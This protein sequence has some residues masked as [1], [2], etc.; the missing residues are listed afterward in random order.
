MS[1]VREQAKAARQ[2]GHSSRDQHQDREIEG[3][4]D[5]LDELAELDRTPDTEQPERR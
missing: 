5:L 3:Q 2:R 4:T 1:N